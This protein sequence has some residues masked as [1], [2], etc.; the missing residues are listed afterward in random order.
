MIRAVICDDEKAA[1]SIIRRFIEMENLPI[2]IVGTA[3]TGTQALQ[4]IV[5]EK[6]DLIFMDIQMPYLDGFEVI[7]KAPKSKVIVITAHD[8]FDYA[9]KA[10]RLGVS[11]I[12]SKP[13]GLDQLRQSIARAIGWNFTS[14]SVVNQVLEYIH[15]HYQ[16]QIDLK[17]LSKITYCTESHL[18]HLF[19]KNTGMTILA[20]VHKIRIEKSLAYLKE[21]NLSIREISEEVGYQNLNNYY[22]HFKRIMGETPASYLQK[23]KGKQQK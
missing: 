21:G 20:Y 10:L 5:R 9:Q 11:D 22:K 7:Q 13:I 8:S 4:L 17:M 12:L 14:N 3:E 23:L 15:S 6:P 18:A 2:R 1:I 19:K 16:E